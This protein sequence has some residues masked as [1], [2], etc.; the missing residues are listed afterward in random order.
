M[1]WE[2]LEID[3]F[4]KSVES[5]RSCE[6]FQE[7]GLILHQGF[8]KR[9]EI[10]IEYVGRSFDATEVRGVCRLLGLQ[11]GVRIYK[12]QEQFILFLLAELKLMELRAKFE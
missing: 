3:K 4:L 8:K 10:I 11:M 1:S 6:A 7:F 12:L 5:E 9:V 2:H